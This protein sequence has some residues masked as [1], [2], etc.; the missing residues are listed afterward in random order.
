VLLCLSG[1]ALGTS[2]S[3][4]W[5]STGRAGASAGADDV[6]LAGRAPCPD[7]KSIGLSEATAGADP[8][9]PPSALPA[10]P[11]HVVDVA[12]AASAGSKKH[13]EPS[14][15]CFCVT[16]T[17][18]EEIELVRAQY[19]AN[20]SIFSCDAWQ[21]FSSD[22]V[23]LRPG[24]ATTAIPGAP[25]VWKERPGSAFKQSLNANVFLRAW[26]SLQED[27]RY[28]NHDWVVKLDA[29]TV[30]LPDR[31]KHELG[32]KEW[33]WT[34]RWQAAVYVK[35]CWKFKSMQ[36][37]L[38]I[39]SRAAVD[40]LGASVGECEAG[41][42]YNSMGEDQFMDKCLHKL[43]VQSINDFEVLSDAYC[44]DDSSVTCN[45]PGS[46]SQ[47]VLAIHPCKT[48]QTYFD[49]LDDTSKMQI[50]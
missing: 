46:G 25:A 32:R 17:W 11:S 21:V 50:G 12:P 29:D 39:I 33:A 44:S 10:A 8:C 4:L 35:N 49:C 20:A 2:P 23:E 19:K 45:C 5:R 42:D 6:E 30:F 43:G 37:P 22:P 18:G 3:Q 38:E 31:L 48:V 16:V 34:M 13:K 24:L 1:W 40:R 9:K 47:R 27:G 7:D 15:F 41:M 26:R 14:L 28:Q 36:G